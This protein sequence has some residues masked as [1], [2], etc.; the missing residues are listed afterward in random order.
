MPEGV[1]I[2]FSKYIYAPLQDKDTIPEASIVPFI[3]YKFQNIKFAVKNEWGGKTG[4]DVIQAISSFDGTTADQYSD[5]EYVYMGAYFDNNNWAFVGVSPQLDNWTNDKNNKITE[6]LKHFQI[7]EKVIQPDDSLKQDKEKWTLISQDEKKRFGFKED[8]YYNWQYFPITFGEWDNGQSNTFSFKLNE[9]EDRL[10]VKDSKGVEKQYYWTPNSKIYCFAKKYSISEQKNSKHALNTLDK[11]PLR[12]NICNYLRG[13]EPISA[14]LIEALGIDEQTKL[15]S[16]PNGALGGAGSM[17]YVDGKEPL[18]AKYILKPEISYSRIIPTHSYIS[19]NANSVK[20]SWN[21]DIKYK[22]IL[23]FFTTRKQSSLEYSLSRSLNRYYYYGMRMGKNSHP[24]EL[25]DVLNTDWNKNGMLKYQVSLNGIFFVAG[26]G[27]NFSTK[28]ISSLQFQ[29]QEDF[30]STSS[31]IQQIAIPYNDTTYVIGSKA[32]AE[33]HTKTTPPNGMWNIISTSCILPPGVH[34][35]DIPTE[36]NYIIQDSSNNYHIIPS[37]CKDVY[38]G[39]SDGIQHIKQFV[40]NNK[41]TWGLSQEANLYINLFVNYGTRAEYESKLRSIVWT[42]MNTTI[43][44]NRK[45][46]YKEIA[47]LMSYYDEIFEPLGYGTT[48]IQLDKLAYQDTVIPNN[49]YYWDHND[50]TA[51]LFDAQNHE[52]SQCNFDKDYLSGSTYDFQIQ[53]SA[54]YLLEFVIT[55]E[56]L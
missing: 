49:Y 42:D 23:H 29:Y 12:I 33:D 45:F 32:K 8:Y 36:Y 53:E 24:E 40:T 5:F 6:V 2:D 26:V 18:S 25:E 21:I 39:I 3:K 31:N 4:A 9:N 16:A 20:D 17:V 10:I 1:K 38:K 14:D 11:Y 27:V 37:N 46:T 41:I 50:N 51:K 47:T 34:I 52:M 54:P 19:Y 28:P 35:R 30:C 55:T 22:N 13:Q 48:P 15:I 43:T 44:S 56:D 7:N